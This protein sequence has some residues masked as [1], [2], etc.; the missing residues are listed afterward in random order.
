MKK[1]NSVTI[2]NLVELDQ[3]L[4][5]YTIFYFFR[6]LKQILLIFD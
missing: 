4:L 6:S 1:E 5:N 3:I 2:L